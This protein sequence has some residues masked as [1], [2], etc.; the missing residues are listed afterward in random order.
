M[1]PFQLK[2]GFDFSLDRGESN[3]IDGGACLVN[4]F[5]LLS[6]S[7][8]ASVRPMPLSSSSAT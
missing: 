6:V 5:N 4:V 8:I 3:R 2:Q 1:G 7:T